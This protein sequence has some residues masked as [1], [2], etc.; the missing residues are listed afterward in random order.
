M[1]DREKEMV[2]PFWEIREGFPEEVTRKG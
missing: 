2:T 1:E